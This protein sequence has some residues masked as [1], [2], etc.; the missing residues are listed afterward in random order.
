MG[1]Q[2]V[3]AHA[4]RRFL[5]AE[6][7]LAIGRGRKRTAGETLKVSAV[8]FYVRKKGPR[9]YDATSRIPARL[10]DRKAN[11]SADRSRWFRTDVREVGAVE[12]VSSG[13][14]LSS[15]FRRGTASLVFDFPAGGEGAVYALTCAHVIGDVHMASPGFKR[16]K[17]ALPGSGFVR[18]G[19]LRQVSQRNGR[20]EFDI[21]I[22]KLD[23][24]APSVP[25]RGVP[26]DDTVFTRFTKP[27]LSH[28]RRVKIL[29]YKTGRVTRGRIVG[30]LHTPLSIDFNAGP[31]LVRNLYVL[32]DFSPKSGDSGGIIY[33]RDRAIGLV[34]A[35]FSTGGCLF[36]S[37][38]S[39]TKRLLRHSSLGLDVD[40]IF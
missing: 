3:I 21:A 12:L 35:K 2:S 34:V 33:S 11:G 7:V 8:I 23:D 15:S 24:R 29:G 40:R 37:L 17:L 30:P 1:V 20:L 4:R 22:A 31:L 36:H 27:P 28:G 25:L 10:C 18:G 14:Q 39:A 13:R 38:Y 32:D 19:R 5:A 26:D 9:N 16:V 6:N